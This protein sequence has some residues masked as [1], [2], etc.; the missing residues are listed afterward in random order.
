M[1][2]DEPQAEN[3]TRDVD[4]DEQSEHAQ[5]RNRRIDESMSVDEV[6][7]ERREQFESGCEQE[8][9]YGPRGDGGD[10]QRARSR[11]PAACNAVSRGMTAVPIGAS[12]VMETRTTRSA[13]PK[14]A[15]AALD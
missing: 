10:Q 9:R 2:R 12:T 5:D 3:D 1:Q 13:A 6:N 11:L 15:T 14:C 8:C 4:G 7:D